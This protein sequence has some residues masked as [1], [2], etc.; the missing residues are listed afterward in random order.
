LQPARV[1][2]EVKKRKSDSYR[3]FFFYL[4]AAGRF[5]LMCMLSDVLLS[6]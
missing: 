5:L 1:K 6:I 3:T 4:P 2:I